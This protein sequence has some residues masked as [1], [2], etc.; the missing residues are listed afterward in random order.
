MNFT[1][2]AVAGMAI[3]IGAGSLTAVGAVMQGEGS[4]PDPSQCGGTYVQT[5]G[6]TGYPSG[7]GLTSFDITAD[8]VTERV[9]ALDNPIPAGSYDLSAITYDGYDDR[10]TVVTE[11]NEQ[12][13]IDFLDVDGNVLATSGVSGDLDDGVIEAT[14]SGTLG[15]VSWTGASATRVRTVHAFPGGEITNSIRP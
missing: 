15:Q 1:R 14:W 3:A 13:Y 9:W 7:S 8:W 12:L 2:V 10:P 6:T 4:G 5:F 11:P